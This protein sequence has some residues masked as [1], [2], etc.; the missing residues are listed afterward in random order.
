VKK[1]GNICKF[2]EALFY[3]HTVLACSLNYFRLQELE[4]QMVGGE[5]CDNEEMRERRKNRQLLGSL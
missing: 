5:Q 2:S 4:R 1:N 3:R